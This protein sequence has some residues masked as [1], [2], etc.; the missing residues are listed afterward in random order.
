MLYISVCIDIK[1]KEKKRNTHK[2]GIER[3][4][5]LCCSVKLVAF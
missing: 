3:R 1:I 5:R 4:T 2:K